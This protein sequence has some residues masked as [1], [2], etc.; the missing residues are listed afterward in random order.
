MFI[1]ALNNTWFRSTSIA[2]YSGS[3]SIVNG[4]GFGTMQA[5]SLSVL[6]FES[7]SSAEALTVT[8][9]DSNF[10][11]SAKGP[12]NRMAMWSLQ[13]GTV[14]SASLSVVRNRILMTGVSSSLSSAA[15]VAVY[16]G[17]DAGFGSVQVQLNASVFDLQS[18]Q[19]AAIISLNGTRPSFNSSVLTID[20]GCQVIAGSAL[21]AFVFMAESVGGGNVSSTTIR[22]IR[23]EIDL[24]ATDT[25]GVVMLS[26]ALEAADVA[27][28]ILQATTL[29]VETMQGTQASIFNDTTTRRSNSAFVRIADGAHVSV[30]SP[31]AS[32]LS[33]L[34]GSSSPN[35]NRQHAVEIFGTG[36]Q[37]SLVVSQHDDAPVAPT[38][39]LY[40]QAPCAA[41]VVHIH[42]GAMVN[43]TLDSTHAQVGVAIGT[44][45]SSAIA[46]AVSNSAVLSIQSLL[47]A[48]ASFGQVS[49]VYLSGANNSAVPYQ[50]R[51]MDSLSV[52][53][54]NSLSSPPAAGAPVF[55]AAGSLTEVVVTAATATASL[56]EIVGPDALPPRCVLN[57]ACYPGIVSPT[58]DI[59]S[60]AAVFVTSESN[61]ATLLRLE[62]VRF[63]D[64]VPTTL[65]AVTDFA[66]SVFCRTNSTQNS[67]NVAAAVVLV[68]AFYPTS[69]LIVTCA[70]GAAISVGS[71]ASRAAFVMTDGPLTVVG[72][73]GAGTERAL[74]VTIQDDAS[75]V[76]ESV[77]SAALSVRGVQPVLYPNGPM[78]QASLIVS[79]GG[80]LLMQ[81]AQRRTISRFAVV[82]H[83]GVVSLCQLIVSG[84]GSVVKVGPGE[85]PAV[86]VWVYRINNATRFLAAIEVLDRGSLIVGNPNDCTGSSCAV[87]MVQ[88]V[89]TQQPSGRNYSVAVKVAGGSTVRLVVGTGTSTTAMFDA[90]GLA[91]GLDVQDVA[92]SCDNLFVPFVLCRNVGSLQAYVA[93]SVVTI[94]SMTPSLAAVAFATFVPTV[95]TATQTTIALLDGSA[96]SLSGTRVALLE[97]DATAGDV[98][99]LGNITIHM[100]RS[101][102]TLRSTTKTAAV[103][104]M[105][106]M[107]LSNGSG[108]AALTVSNSSFLLRSGDSD[109]Q[110]F[111][112]GRRQFRMAIVAQDFSAAF[113]NGSVV[114]IEGAGTVAVFA[115]DNST[116]LLDTLV[117]VSIDE[118]DVTLQS[119]SSDVGGGDVFLVLMTTIDPYVRSSYRSVQVTISGTSD[120]QLISVSAN[121][122]NAGLLEVP[123][124]SPGTQ[125]MATVY[126]GPFAGRLTVESRQVSN[127]VVF[128]PA[129]DASLLS[130]SAPGDAGV[131]VESV[132]AYSVKLEGR[133]KFGQIPTITL[134]GRRAFIFG[135]SATTPL[136]PINATV[137]LMSVAVTTVSEGDNAAIEFGFA[138][139]TLHF[140][141][142]AAAL[143]VT[144]MDG[145]SK[146]I[147]IQ[148]VG[149]RVL[150][151]LFQ[152]NVTVFGGAYAG[153]IEIGN[154]QQDADVIG[155]VTQ[156]SNVVVSANGNATA[157]AVAPR[158]V[159]RL[160]V[161]IATGTT[162]IVKELAP[163]GNA[164][165]QRGR[166]FA[167]LLI[168][169]GKEAS[170]SGT[171]E[172]TTVG[173]Q[174]ANSTLALSSAHPNGP[175]PPAAA[176]AICIIDADGLWG[177][178]TRGA[179]P[180]AGTQFAMNDDGT[181]A[182]TIVFKSL[183]FI[184]QNAQLF[185]SVSLG[186][187]LP[188]VA[189]APSSIS[190]KFDSVVLRP[191]DVA[192]AGNALIG[193]AGHLLMGSYSD[194][195]VSLTNLNVING[196]IQMGNWTCLGQRGA[197]IRII[198]VSVTYD[199][200][201]AELFR[202]AVPPPADSVVDMLAVAAAL[203]GDSDLVMN[204]IVIGGI[205]I[206]GADVFDAGQP[207]VFDAVTIN[208]T[209]FLPF[210]CG[211]LRL[212]RV[213]AS[214]NIGA[215]VL[216]QYV[217]V[218]TR[219]LS[220]PW[221]PRNNQDFVFA[222]TP[223]LLDIL[224]L[225]PAWYR[226]LALG[227][228][229][230][231]DVRPQ[232]VP[233]ST[234]LSLS[235][236]AE[237][238]I[239]AVERIFISATDLS[240]S[241]AIVDPL[242]HADCSSFL[243]GTTAATSTAF[244]VHGFSVAGSALAF[245]SIGSPL[246]IYPNV[247][248]VVVLRRQ[249]QLALW[250]AALTE[251]PRSLVS[252]VTTANAWAVKVRG[253]NIDVG[254]AHL[255][256]VR[257]NHIRV[258]VD[259]PVLK[260][261]GCVGGTATCLPTFAL[262]FAGIASS[263]SDG[264]SSWTLDSN[265]IE[266]SVDY[267]VNSTWQIIAGSVLT[268]RGIDLPRSTATLNYVTPNVNVLRNIISLDV[269]VG[270][271]A[272]T[273]S[274]TATVSGADV[275]YMTS[276]I[277]NDI[278]VIVRLSWA[279]LTVTGMRLESGTTP[280]SS[281][282]VRDSHVVV[283][284]PDGSLSDLS[285]GKTVSLWG[286]YFTSC[287]VLLLPM[288]PDGNRG[289]TT[290]TGNTLAVSMD[291]SFFTTAVVAAYG[292][293]T[294]PS[295]AAAVSGP[296]DCI[297]NV[298]TLW[299]T[300]SAS[301]PVDSLIR[302]HSVG[303]IHLSR[304]ALQGPTA[305]VSVNTVTIDGT[306]LGG[307]VPAT[308]RFSKLECISV[309]STGM[310]GAPT[311]CSNTSRWYLQSNAMSVTF[312]SGSV[313]AAGLA[314]RNA[315]CFEVIQI[316]DNTVSVSMA[317]YWVA[318]HV[319]GMIS[320][321]PADDSLT[322][323]PLNL[324]ASQLEV[325]S[326]TVLF[327][328]NGSVYGLPL[329][330]DGILPAAF[331]LNARLAGPSTNIAIGSNVARMSVPKLAQADAAS[332]LTPGRCAAFRI[333]RYDVATTTLVARDN[334]VAV[335]LGIHISPNAASA[336][337]TDL[338]HVSVAAFDLVRLYNATLVQ[339][340]FPQGIVI[341]SLRTNTMTFDLLPTRSG[342]SSRPSDEAVHSL[343]ISII[344]TVSGSVDVASTILIVVDNTLTASLTT[345]TQSQRVDTAIVFLSRLVFY[346][347]AETI[348]ITNNTLSLNHADASRTYD[349]VPQALSVSV[350]RAITSSESVAGSHGTPMRSVDADSNAVSV[351]SVAFALAARSSMMAGIIAV[352][353][354]AAEMPPTKSVLLANL[355][356]RSAGNRV[357][358][359]ASTGYGIAV[360]APLIRAAGL[361]NITTEGC[362][363]ESALKAFPNAWT[364][365][366]DPSCDV[367]RLQ[368]QALATSMVFQPQSSPW[369]IPTVQDQDGSPLKVNIPSTCLQTAT[370]T[371]LIPKLMTVTLTRSRSASVTPSA[372][373]TTSVSGTA[374]V[375][376]TTSV[377]ATSTLSP[378]PS[379]TLNAAS[380]SGT[381][382]ATG[383]TTETRIVPARTGT[384]HLS[385]T[386]S[387]SPSPQAWSPS[388]SRSP[389]VTGVPIIPP[390]LPPVLPKAVEQATTAAAATTTVVGSLASPAAALQMARVV[391]VLQI[392]KRC[393]SPGGVT[394]ESAYDEELQFP[395][396]L[397]PTLHFGAARGQY[398]RGAVLGNAI[399]AA[400]V[401]SVIICIGVAVASVG[402]FKPRSETQ[403][404][405]GVE[406]G[407][408]PTPLLHRA[409]RTVRMPGGVAVVVSLA[410]D[411][412]VTGAMILLTQSE[413]KAADA[414][415]IAIAALVNLATLGFIVYQ[416]RR[417]ITAPLRISRMTRADAAIVGATVPLLGGS[418]STQR[419][420][421]D[422]FS[423]SSPPLEYLPL[424]LVR[425]RSGEP[426]ITNP[427][428][429]RVTQWAF[430]GESAW[431]PATD[432]DYALD[433]QRKHLGSSMEGGVLPDMLREDHL[434]RRAFASYAAFEG[435][436][437]LVSRYRG[438]APSSPNRLASVLAVV[439]YWSL[440]VDL[441][442]T[443]LVA[444]SQ[445]VATLYCREATMLA[446]VA[447]TVGFLI[448][449]VVRPYTVPAKNL[450]LVITTALMLGASAATAAAVAAT[451]DATADKLAAMAA[452]AAAA[453]AMFGFVAIALSMLRVILLRV[454]LRS[455][456]RVDVSRILVA[457]KKDHGDE[458][459]CYVTSE[460]MR[461][462]MQEAD[463]EPLLLELSVMLTPTQGAVA[464]TAPAALPVSEEAQGGEPPPQDPEPVA[465]SA[466]APPT[467]AGDTDELL[468]ALLGSAQERRRAFYDAGPQR[469][470]YRT[471]EGQQ[472]YADLEAMLNGEPLRQ[473]RRV[474]VPPTHD[475]WI[476]SLF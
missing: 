336:R 277:Q 434:R 294:D 421:N 313:T 323:V 473:Q 261:Q 167:A 360:A 182:N 409:L 269:R 172:W 311:T 99:V 145:A 131:S 251:A 400:V 462:M 17:L 214:P 122:A 42:S 216:L 93:R 279:S 389:T 232:Q 184:S 243:A 116:R 204:G 69:D 371:P 322:P 10:T 444:V 379:R 390:T 308:T 284:L 174:V 351:V 289:S 376:G 81:S 239:V 292:I 403:Y 416:I 288:N 306:G 154:V 265:V 47:N 110:V 290:L 307:D 90:G 238:C 176:C 65:L 132:G 381:L 208:V 240:A 43:V 280:S 456:L 68:Q 342:P 22:M 341:G 328:M 293:M 321:A 303:G 315:W 121:S 32:Y 369:G 424:E 314:L 455:A 335:E 34:G 40:T 135:P 427:L 312:P 241:E 440:P 281:V 56:V 331:A 242:L 128:S 417:L 46:V 275:S 170:Y 338:G 353:S 169:A 433:E 23:S 447:N 467:G 465:Q 268:V 387:L 30:T 449:V 420:A 339:P 235:V 111:A 309:Q 24:S 378:S 210:G 370:A 12:N 226:A 159:Q 85:G 143:T 330:G 295:T 188:A 228:T 397:L 359:S 53:I 441:I 125:Q 227:N 272:S 396:S 74:N 247:L 26:G 71:F 133:L 100:N 89:S 286:L 79:G 452:Q 426:T 436:G 3:V 402:F 59:N 393:R 404:A 141:A 15:V 388:A 310:T 419:E 87:I 107:T 108:A 458:D 152:S 177:A 104:N 256:A 329:N 203:A 422:V 348:S 459:A 250:A 365:S 76:I 377:S 413:T 86:G 197:T 340:L 469:Q 305:N 157:I 127:I 300:R 386:P 4:N 91:M 64:P 296:I 183:T 258:L 255:H 36:T 2:V 352:A 83:G 164:T 438:P 186:A 178:P 405:A 218:T 112:V 259:A 415:M 37:L 179:F 260:Q 476:D 345:A 325:F 77:E 252:Y 430:F 470:V 283:D 140:A 49:A 334:A 429:K 166:Y 7:S 229:V 202:A 11:I 109:A 407:G 254:V 38:A 201:A 468:D 16:E 461:S 138:R 457:A 257:S 180:P 151:T 200:P 92:I 249:R 191:P 263:K 248:T 156:F 117:A 316:T 158:R 149:V 355:T 225:L 394:A 13:S 58:I 297:R 98:D 266:L 118:S 274:F 217:T 230:G 194:V 52:P 114:L 464:A 1:A 134:Q 220:W 299:I 453:A 354:D 192:P 245:L 372:S 48:N 350:L 471:A 82:C 97:A 120:R 437:V 155:V 362:S 270:R 231:I 337:H 285:G 185:G 406:S 282:V 358:L 431:L 211:G 304:Y 278:T 234:G 236:R 466:S 193:A 368:G 320:V 327:K 418:T 209:C 55:V 264:A 222:G 423:S 9:T 233:A 398:Y 244:G 25:A 445:G 80:S 146:Q 410:L 162:V 392:A 129:L 67:G 253:I 105:N 446:L 190:V 439:A 317:D 5:V 196:T 144:S 28:H 302:S 88:N 276:V 332:P 50:S 115:M 198:N 363:G 102:C 41:C 27:L 31:A 181:G 160:E 401:I 367:F 45:G 326:N 324:T 126:V 373:G 72:T 428:L 136:S 382:N 414:V 175:P 349:A 374:S 472:R 195:N 319:S 356:A 33:Y 57:A 298:V 380:P 35:L 161:S 347:T 246:A 6:G 346:P 262:I 14:S 168:G 150:A 207:V 189:G 450:L 73:T 213:A 237:K 113:N 318:S 123:V 94:G 451:S 273:A 60:G 408:Q 399:V 20:D 153:A 148:A 215:E 62:R 61:N 411:G 165:V 391:G 75:V 187:K 54:P 173:V 63:V 137:S 475:S 101:S 343:S 124:G 44:G 364:M 39:L 412:S 344:D 106:R 84:V 219:S 29:N 432:K 21:R 199:A 395:Q 474:D 435:C 223:Q 357:T 384:R 119:T 442:L 205:D 66:S 139:G 460:S 70:H 291:A 448:A 361:V 142:T 95:A 287:C 51:I 212:T 271:N 18:R 206:T 147:A 333:W 463:D 224:A 163:T 96:I 443:M 130:L 425:H 103:L 267:V 8:S 19:T 171:R 383:T 301:V 366:G 454:V 78:L 385:S 375:S 221:L